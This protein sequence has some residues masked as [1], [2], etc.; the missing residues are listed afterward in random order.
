MS[1]I[2]LVKFSV[3]WGG[4]KSAVGQIY[5]LFCLTSSQVEQQ[6][7]ESACVYV[8]VCMCVCECVCVCVCECVYECVCV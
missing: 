7:C 6:S 2:L 3:Y 1:N 4:G 8:C 5:Q